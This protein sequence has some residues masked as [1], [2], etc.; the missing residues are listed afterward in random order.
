M[1]LMNVK[2]TIEQERLLDA[3][4]E[5]AKACIESRIPWKIVDSQATIAKRI[6]QSERME[7]V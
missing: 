4:L 6:I 7:E 1:K 5:A 2:L 3:Q